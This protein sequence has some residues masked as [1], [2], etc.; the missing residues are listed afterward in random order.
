VRGA[1]LGQLMITLGVGLLLHE[2]ANKA[3]SLTGGVDGL[4]DINMWRVLGVFRFDLA[5]KTAYIYCLVVAFA[6]FLL[7]RRILSSPF[8]LSLRAI[9]EGAARMSA[10]G[11]SVGRRQVA[12][13]TLAAA[14]AGVAGG[15]LAQTTQFVALEVLSFDRSAAVLIILVLGGAGRIYG[16]FV[17]AGL[18]MLVQDYL[19]RRD[20]VYWQVWIGG[21]LVVVVLFSRGGVLGLAETLRDRLRERQRRPQ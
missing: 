9:R 6:A 2:A 18:F 7:V 4:S 1:A 3:H 20:P 14:L 5:G 12:A 13:F 17:G 8:G 21:L 16:A 19:S 11:V 10:L 15:L